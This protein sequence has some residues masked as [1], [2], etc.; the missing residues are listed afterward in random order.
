MLP[1]REIDEIVEIHNREGSRLQEVFVEGSEDKSF[2][3]SFLSANGLKNVAVLDVGTVNVPDARVV[4]LGLKV[5]KKGRVITLAATLESRVTEN[6]VVCIADAD[7]DYVRGI[8]YEYSLLLLTDYTSIELYVLCPTVL[9]RIIHVALRGFPKGHVQV[10]A[11]LANL[12]QDAFIVRVAAEDLNLAPTFPLHNSFCSSEKRHQLTSFNLL[13]YVNKAFESYVDKSWRE[14]LNEKIAERRANLKADPRLQIHGHDFAETF[15]WY[16]RQHP[17]F[18]HI[19]ADTFSGML[20]GFVDPAALA[21][22]PLFQE[23]LRRLRVV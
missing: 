12:L 21:H 11:E 1:T 14:P 15:A 9:E 4:D 10:T 6:Q 17:G 18:A 7:T 16:V 8:K 22:E 3:E 2:F 23:L 13:G 5:G 20:L 19:N